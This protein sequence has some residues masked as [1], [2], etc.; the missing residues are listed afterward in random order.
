MKKIIPL[1]FIVLLSGCASKNLNTE[2]KPLYEIIDQKEYGGASI[3]FFEIVSEPEEFAMIK[4]DPELKKKVNPNDILTANFLILNMGE[5]T[6]GGYS[7]T[8]GKVEETDK[9]IIVSVKE[10]E[11]EPGAMVTNAMTNPYTIVKINS[12]KEIII[13]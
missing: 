1:C 7:I 3:R 11:P 8:I 6:T 4:N 12:K 5:K 2:T 13:Q 9:N 10:K